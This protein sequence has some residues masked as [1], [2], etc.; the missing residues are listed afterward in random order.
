MNLSEMAI[1]CLCIWETKTTMA[2]LM[3]TE[4]SCESFDIGKHFPASLQVALDHSA[5]LYCKK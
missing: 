2:T 1:Q 5:I 3:S 4:M